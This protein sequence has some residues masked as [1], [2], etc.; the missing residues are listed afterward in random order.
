[1]M[2][3]PR[4]EDEWRYRVGQ[5]IL[6][7]YKVIKFPDG[8][9]F[10]E[11]FY[12]TVYLTSDLGTNSLRVIKQLKQEHLQDD[13]IRSRFHQE[14]K[15]FQ[16]I[17]HR[18]VV[19]VDALETEDK[20]ELLI[21]EYVKGGSLRDL[22]ERSGGR[23]SVKESLR[24]IRSALK[25]LAAIHRQG[26]TH[27]DLKPENVLLTL[28]RVPKI[29]DLG[30]G[31]IP[32]EI[33]GYSQLTSDSERFRLG[34]LQ[35]MSPEQTMRKEERLEFMG[36][37]DLDERSDLYAVGAMLY[38]LLTGGFYFDREKYKTEYD[39]VNAIR[40]VKV[41][42]PPQKV[43]DSNSWPS[44]LSAAVLRS[45]EKHPKDRFKTAEIFRHWLTA[46]SKAIILTK[47]AVQSLD[48]EL[49]ERYAEKLSV[50]QRKIARFRRA[51]LS[52]DEI[53]RANEVERAVRQIEKEVLWA[54]D[55]IRDGKASYEEL[56]TVQLAV[57]VGQEFLPTNETAVFA[58]CVACQAP[59]LLV[60]FVLGLECGVQVTHCQ[61]K[62]CGISLSADGL[63]TLIKSKDY[64]GLSFLERYA[65]RLA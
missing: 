56:K 31:H 17:D 51:F 60:K 50:M 59:T 57:L 23:L 54:A 44:W 47:V 16:S 61:C 24:I 65:D 14:A 4:L 53:T 27:R 2:S 45:L 34:T 49:V 26:I 6:D 58:E 28:R 10:R 25:G 40:K 42:P 63:R 19:K 38:E 9:H 29:S 11:G 12:G 52:L 32:R 39:V 62:T 1:M 3:E 46:H 5:V 41:T 64:E 21:M 8:K 48:W 20:R 22:L 37:E 36:S 35:Y 43:R 13:R 7:R 30:V 18:N 55:Y 15:A 33:G